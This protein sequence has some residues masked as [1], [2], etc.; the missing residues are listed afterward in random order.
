MDIISG[1]VPRKDHPDFVKEDLFDEWIKYAADNRS[2]ESVTQENPLPEMGST[3]ET[4]QGA[5][6]GTKEDMGAESTEQESVEVELD[7]SA[8]KEPSGQHKEEQGKEEE[9]GCCAKC[10]GC[11]C[12]I[13]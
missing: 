12:G 1:D 2:S 11:C 5:G 9:K 13:I 6:S 3:P 10:C 8:E 7:A 4:A